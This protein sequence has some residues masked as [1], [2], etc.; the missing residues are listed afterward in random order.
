MRGLTSYDL[1]RRGGQPK[2]EGVG[3]SDQREQQVNKRV[4]P[5]LAQCDRL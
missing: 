1:G 2:E 4:H 5:Q 3:D